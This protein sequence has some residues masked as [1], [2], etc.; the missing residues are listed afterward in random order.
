MSSIQSYLGSMKN[1]ELVRDWL[2]D[3]MAAAEKITKGSATYI[4]GTNGRKKT[5]GLQAASKVRFTE[6]DADNTGGVKDQV[7]V[8]TVKS[9]A[10]IC[11]MAGGTIPVDSDVQSAAAGKVVALAAGGTTVATVLAF[12]TN[13]LARYLGKP[14]EVD[15]TGK[16]LSAA[17]NGDEIFIYVY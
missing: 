8:S 10:I 15:E 13:K 14:G 4:D 3:G 11:V 17:A 12:A 7:K 1:R 6:I 16:N 2:V 5:A 9:G